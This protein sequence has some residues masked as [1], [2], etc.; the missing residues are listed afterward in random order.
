VF[1]RNITSIYLFT[2]AAV[3]F[4]CLLPLGTLGIRSL[5]HF[6]SFDILVDPSVLS[7]LI[8]SLTLAF[9]SL[10]LSLCLA[11][12]VSYWLSRTDLPAR[13][14]LTALLNFPFFLPS[15]LFAIAW[16]VL[17]L[18]KVGLLNRLFGDTFFNIYSFSGL[19]LVTCNA[20]L[21]L[22][23]SSLTKS[24]ASMDP[25][26]EEAARLCGASPTRTFFRITL[27]CQVSNM[28]GLS[29]VFLF[30]VLSSFGIP[31]I[32]GNPAKL[33]VLTTQIFT[34]SKMGGLEGADRGFIIS[35]WLILISLGL[36]FVARFLRKKYQVALIGGKASRASVICLGKIRWICFLF[37]GFLIFALVI[38]PLGALFL[39][40]LMRVS[41][42]LGLQNFSLENYQYLWRL[43][44]MG[45]AVTNSI[46]LALLGSMTCCGL[47]FFVAYFS[48][49]THRRGISWLE[50]CAAVPF[51]VPGTVMGL[52]FIVSFG[53]GWG[54]SSLSILGTPFILYFAY[55]AKDLAI[56]VHNLVPALGHIDRSLDEAGRICGANE[57]RVLDKILFPLSFE[58]L[59]TVLLLSAIPMLTELTMS[60][61]LFGPGTETLGTLIFQLQDYSNP[62]A[63]CAL[64]SE[65]VICVGLMVFLLKKSERMMT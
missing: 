52:A 59:K 6:R 29:L 3:F 8:I 40:S 19:V 45:I 32:I 28:I 2:W 34:V 10:F 65:V 1:T 12:P 11:L 50:K 42:E 43:K 26:L 21:P 55:V 41:G 14:A 53:T 4:F 64:A 13:G 37:V 39:S 24:F 17:A 33:Y 62:Q 30:T 16:V 35:L 23:I 46:S 5:T 9:S 61:L 36:S 48:Q 7:S 63:A 20:F 54:L 58:T 15:Y 56:A 25:S 57:L 27:P 38:L 18:P 49:R 60:V 22:L 47:G 31:A 51:S 44:E